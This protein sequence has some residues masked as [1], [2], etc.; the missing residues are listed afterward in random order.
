MIY[1]P[2]SERDHIMS[3]GSLTLRADADKTALFRLELCWHSD[4][5]L[6]FVTSQ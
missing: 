2:A 4:C 3:T 6:P 1:H 5:N